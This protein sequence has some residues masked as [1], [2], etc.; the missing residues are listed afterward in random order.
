MVGI[1]LRGLQGELIVV[2]SVIVVKK[3]VK[4]LWI[5]IEVVSGS[6]LPLYD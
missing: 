5:I 6:S 4:L 1:K 2:F 3:E